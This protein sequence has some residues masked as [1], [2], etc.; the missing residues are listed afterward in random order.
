LIA[1]ERQIGDVAA[2]QDIETAV[3]EDE[4]LARRVEFVTVCAA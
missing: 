2:M 1:R 4:F 3:R